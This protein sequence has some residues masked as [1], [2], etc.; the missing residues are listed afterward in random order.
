MEGTSKRTPEGPRQ[1]T[2]ADTNG[3][4]DSN[5]TKTPTG[6]KQDNRLR[7]DR[8]MKWNQ[9]HRATNGHQ[10]RTPQG[11]NKENEYLR[12]QLWGSSEAAPVL[13]LWQL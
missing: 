3:T 7:R 8:A 4:E 13:S 9:R 5:G 1:T 2:K 6:P 12:G 10:Q 11:P